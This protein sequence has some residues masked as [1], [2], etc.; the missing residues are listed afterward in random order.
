MNETEELMR[1]RAENA[2]LEKEAKWL[3]NALAKGC[4]R[5]ISS[6]EDRTDCPAIMCG[7]ACPSTSCSHTT[8]KDWHEA[9]RKA[10]EG[11]R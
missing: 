5:D 8:P 3:A 10:V 6:E 4:K 9:A 11:N 7:T 1:L 2:R